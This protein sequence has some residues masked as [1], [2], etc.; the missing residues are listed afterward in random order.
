[1]ENPAL[2]A[3]CV[4]GA[5]R[6]VPYNSHSYGRVWLRAIHRWPDGTP[7][8]L[9]R[10]HRWVAGVVPAGAKGTL[11][12][13]HPCNPDL[14][15]IVF[16]NFASKDEEFVFGVALPLGNLSWFVA[17]GEPEPNAIENELKELEELCIL[18][19]DW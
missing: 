2:R 9:Y 4:D 14:L 11:M 1:M 18:H 7:R 17:L 10:S 16:D 15:H 3:L 6:L 12:D 8:A 13:G 19:K 5:Q